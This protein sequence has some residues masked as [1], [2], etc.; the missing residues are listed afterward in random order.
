MYSTEKQA[1]REGEPHLQAVDKLQPSSSMA[2]LWSQAT[3]GFRVFHKLIGHVWQFWWNSG[4][5]WTQTTTYI[6]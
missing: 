6:L 3:E 5:F 1:K 2:E 4:V